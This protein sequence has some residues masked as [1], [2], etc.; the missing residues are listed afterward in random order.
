MK[1][2]SFICCILILLFSLKGY[3]QFWINFGW[4]EP[5]CQNCLWMERAMRL[6]PRQAADYHSIIHKYGQRIEKETRKHYRYWDKSAHKIFDLRMD[7]DRRLQRILSPA[8][9]R[10]YVRFARERPQRIHDYRG[11]YNNP[12]YPTHRPSNDCRRYEDNYWKYRWEGDDRHD[13]NNVSRPHYDSRR[14]PNNGRRSSRSSRSER[15]RD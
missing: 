3:S 5:H 11:W 2:T 4:N 6:N 15:D 10:M 14:E 8:Q 9:F 13:H 12:N 7:R 1:R